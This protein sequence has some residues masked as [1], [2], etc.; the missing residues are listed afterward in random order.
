MEP[1]VPAARDYRSVDRF[2]FLQPSH[3]RF[4]LP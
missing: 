2:T 1:F 3:T 4:G